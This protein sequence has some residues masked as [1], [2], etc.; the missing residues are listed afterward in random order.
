VDAGS[1][2]QHTIALSS[3]EAEF[4]ACGR[5]CASILMVS[6]L[7][8]EMGLLT[9][10][11]TVYM[12]SDAGRSLATRMGV[13]KQRHIQTRYLWLQERVRGGDLQVRRVDGESNVADLGT[14]HLDGRRR[15]YLM[16]LM[17][18]KMG[19]RQTSTMQVAT[20]ASLVA[21]AVAD[22]EL[23]IAAQET[24]PRDRDWLTYIVMIVV[25][26]LVLVGLNTLRSAAF[27]SVRSIGTQTDAMDLSLDADILQ[28]SLQLG[29]S[30]SRSTSGSTAGHGHLT[31]YQLKS[32][33]RDKGLAVAGLKRDLV[34]RLDTEAAHR[35]L[36]R[37]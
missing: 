15:D 4:Y 8:D 10:T 33:C 5:V 24:R 34:A 16:D 9:R 1:A 12:D 32:L 27:R 3:G 26:I 7:I 20:I 25:A 29:P 2:S 21:G 18:L 28:P 11:P 14:K 30:T 36:W 31:V 17:G 19:R 6:H 22:G 13:G 37:A 35:A 23:C